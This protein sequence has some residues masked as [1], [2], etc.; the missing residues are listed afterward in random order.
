MDETDI[1]FILFFISIPMSMLVVLVIL[2]IFSVVI[3]HPVRLG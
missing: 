1:T 2:C 3:G